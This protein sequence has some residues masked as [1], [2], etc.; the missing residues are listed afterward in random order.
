MDIYD[1]LTLVLKSVLDGSVTIAD[2][3]VIIAILRNSQL[4]SN[5]TMLLIVSVLIADFITAANVIVHDVPSVIV[6]YSLY[7]YPT[8]NVIV[9]LLCVSWFGQLFLLPI[10]ACVHLYAVIEPLKF[11]QFSIKSFGTIIVSVLV[12]TAFATVPLYFDCCGFVYYING[13]YWSFDYSKTGTAAYDKF[14]L[15]LQIVCFVSML[16]IDIVIIF[17]VKNLN[18]SIS[19]IKSITKKYF[20]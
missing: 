14:N 17:K 15:Y 11:R 7:G 6:G 2:L 4:R 10:I 8:I 18:V 16:A 1:I 9:A 20:L 12:L 3:I 13:N 5:P 19:I